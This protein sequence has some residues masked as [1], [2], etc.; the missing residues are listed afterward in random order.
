MLSTIVVHCFFQMNGALKILSIIFILY[1]F[2]ILINALF[3]VLRFGKFTD[4]KIGLIINERFKAKVCTC[5]V[6][7]AVLKIHEQ[8]P[9]Y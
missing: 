6:D 3:Y 8:E 5:F 1:G 9:G 7:N 4:P 2:T